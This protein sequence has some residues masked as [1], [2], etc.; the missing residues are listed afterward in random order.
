MLA[1]DVSLSD[2]PTSLL[3]V[4]EPTDKEH[5]Y[6]EGFPAQSQGTRQLLAGKQ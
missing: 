4:H 1:E 2:R 6:A 5:H 3:L